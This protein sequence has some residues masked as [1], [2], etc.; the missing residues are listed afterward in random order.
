MKLIF[1]ALALYFLNLGGVRA[2]G[3]S[4]FFYDE[5]GPRYSL[6]GPAPAPS[7][8]TSVAPAAAPPSAPAAPTAQPP[9]CPPED[10]DCMNGR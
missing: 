7:V 1:A 3:F 2:Q 9:A 4:Q 10:A 6:L 8:P 5:F